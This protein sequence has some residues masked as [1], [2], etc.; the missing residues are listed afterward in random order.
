MHAAQILNLIDHLPFEPFEIRMTGG[1]RV[2][3]L[4]AWQIATSPNSASCA[5]YEADGGARII[6][7]ENI[8]EL[9]PFEQLPTTK[10]QHQWVIGFLAFCWILVAGML[11]QILYMTGITPTGPLLGLGFIQTAVAAVVMATV[12]YFAVMRKLEE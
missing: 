7:I 1:A 3:V 10:R 9:L 6:A 12:G 5:V 11:P 4:H 8:A 2:P